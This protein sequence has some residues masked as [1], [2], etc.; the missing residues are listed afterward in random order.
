MQTCCKQRTNI[1]NIVHNFTKLRE[2]YN[3]LHNST[4]LY[5]ALQYYK[6]LYTLYTFQQQSTTL[7]TIL[8]IPTKLYNNVQDSNNVVQHM[9]SQTSTQLV[10]KEN[11]ENKK[12]IHTT[13]F[14]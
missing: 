10:A 5:I 11:F 13:F 14:F 7:F 3:T 6:T 8:K 12:N 4:T 2:F 9:T 1:Y